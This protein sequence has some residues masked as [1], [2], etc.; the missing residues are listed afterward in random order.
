MGDRFYSMSYSQTNA[1]KTQKVWRGFGNNEREG[2][3][4]VENKTRK[5]SWQWAK[6]AGL[7]SDLLQASKGE[8]L[9]A[10]ASTEGTLISAST[11]SG[12]KDER[13]LRISK[14]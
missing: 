2:T 7:Y 1:G 8:C 6:H 14:V 9:L 11:V 12:W 4:K 3:G 13:Y 5:Y 10:M